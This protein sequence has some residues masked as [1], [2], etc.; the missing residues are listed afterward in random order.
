M[1]KMTI[2]QILMWTYNDELPKVDAGMSGPSAAPSSWNAVGEMITLGT[3]VD[4][5]PNRYGVVSSFISEGDPHP[6]A[7]RVYACVNRLQDHDGF[8]I[9]DGWAP[10]PEWTDEHGLI[11]AEVARI[12]GEELGKGGRLNGRHVVNL[13][14][15]AAIIGRGPNW[16]VKAP[17]IA[18]LSK[19]NKPA[20]FVT[21]SAKDGTGRTYTY[22]DDGFD[23]RK[24]RPKKGAYQKFRIVDPIRGAVIARLEWQLWQSALETLHEALSHRLVEIDLQPFFPDRFPWVP[25]RFSA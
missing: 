1:R 18:P 16:D 23:D 7:L 11:S 9:A 19:S 15:N 17:R 4:R 8:E 20:W 5:Q 6:D 21:R 2:E 25:K 22:E 12:V 13:V 3:I 24:K 14:R 10:F